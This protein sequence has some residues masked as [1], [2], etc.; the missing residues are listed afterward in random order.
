M[1]LGIAL[2]VLLPFFLSG[3][4]REAWLVFVIAFVAFGSARLARR[5]W[6]M[7]RHYAA[8]GLVAGSAGLG[9]VLGLI[10][11]SPSDG[12]LTYRYVDEVLMAPEVGEMM[13]VEGVVAPGSVVINQQEDPPMLQFVLERGGAALTV[14]H[15]G[16]PPEMFGELSEVIA[17]GELVE[18]GTGYM[19]EAESLI[20][21]Y[22][23]M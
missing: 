20:A 10:W 1:Q 14:R 12:I 9:L 7:D 17:T 23:R 6:H 4:E 15:R 16:V 11:S 18:D 8:G 21:R 13:R 5:L 2:A 19:L 22:P 3:A